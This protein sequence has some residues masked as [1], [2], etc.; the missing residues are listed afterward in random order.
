MALTMREVGSEGSEPD[1]ILDAVM[2]RQQ[3]DRTAD[4]IAA[5]LALI[6]QSDERWHG[7]AVWLSRSGMNRDAELL[8]QLAA[9][10]ERTERY[11]TERYRAEARASRRREP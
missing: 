11:R 10:M 5:A 3:D 4:R 8:D 1:A 7:L 2:G 9:R 6:R